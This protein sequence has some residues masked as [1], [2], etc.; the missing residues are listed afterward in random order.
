MEEWLLRLWPESRK[1]QYTVPLQTPVS[2]YRSDLPIFQHT[3]DYIV[4]WKQDGVRVLLM[5]AWEKESVFLK[6]ITRKKKVLKTQYFNPNNLPETPK[7]W[8]DGTL[9]DCE[10]MSP[11]VFVVLDVLALGG[12]RKMKQSFAERMKAFDESFPLYEKL[13][14]QYNVFLKKKKWWSFNNFKNC[15]RERDSK[16]DGL[17]FMN[18]NNAYGYGATKQLKKWKE[19]HTIDLKYEKSTGEWLFSDY[20]EKG[21]KNTLTNATVFGIVV[22]GSAPSLS[23][24]YEIEQQQ[25]NGRWVVKQPRHDKRYPNFRT[26]VEDCLK[27]TN[28][29]LTLQELKAFLC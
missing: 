5:F 24:I 1:K 6:T 22:E 7:D 4:G 15:L 19:S 21:G 27:C 14:Q 11:D 29:N 23:G 28:E 9:L 2:L 10:M 17:I 16:E 13:L 18:A 25:I 12:Y 8:F 20:G 26:T 3:Q